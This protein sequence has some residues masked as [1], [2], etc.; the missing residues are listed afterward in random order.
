VLFAVPL[1]RA[2]SALFLAQG[3]LDFFVERHD[4]V[5]GAGAQGFRLMAGQLGEAQQRSLRLVHQRFP[6][7][8]LFA[9]AQWEIADTENIADL[10]PAVR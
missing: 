7:W 10:R 6:P 5:V 4:Q 8:A 3:G 9:I 1:Q 2:E